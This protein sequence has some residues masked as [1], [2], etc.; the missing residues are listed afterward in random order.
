MN[1]ISSYLCQYKNYSEL[2]L[3]VNEILDNLTFGMEADKFESAL[4]NV[5]ELLGFVSQRPDMEIRKGPDNLWCGT[6]NEYAFF[7]CKSEVEETR[8]EIT[9]HE[10][11]Q[12]NNHS[13]WFEKE[14]GSNVFVDRYML[15]PTKNCHILV[16]LPIQLELLEEKS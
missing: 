14:Y 6:N 11:G 8:Q 5:G 7:E 16:I 2:M 10:A 13:A 1:R 15:I 12:M 4:K 9:K 3:A